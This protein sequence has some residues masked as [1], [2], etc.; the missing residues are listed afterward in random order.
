[1]TYF[2]R[3][4]SRAVNIFV[5]LDERN[6]MR[7]VGAK[8]EALNIFKNYLKITDD[9]VPFKCASFGPRE[10]IEPRFEDS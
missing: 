1:M 9:I 5:V 7:V 2:P 6:Q 8:S 10:S 4:L 3:S